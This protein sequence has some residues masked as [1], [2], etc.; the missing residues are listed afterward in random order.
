VRDSGDGRAIVDMSDG[1]SYGPF[2]VAGGP[3]GPQGNSG[4]DG[5]GISEIRN[6]GDGTLTVVFTDGNSA[7]PF[8]LPAGPA[9]PQGLQGEVS[10]ADLSFAIGG[11]S[12]NTNAVQLLDSYA[13]LPTVVAKLN[14]LILAQRR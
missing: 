12:A 10:A 1:S 5:R 6:N 2:T 3:Q 11:T 13:D 9:G 8:P 4:N 7:G 14:E